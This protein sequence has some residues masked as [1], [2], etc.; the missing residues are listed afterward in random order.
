MKVSVSRTRPNPRVPP[1]KRIARG[2]ITDV[3]QML[4]PVFLV[5]C[6]I[7][8]WLILVEVPGGLAD[9]LKISNAIGISIWSVLVWRMR[10]GRVPDLWLMVVAVPVGVFVGCEV[11]AWMGA[12]NLVTYLIEDPQHQWRSMVGNVVIASFATSFVF[13]FHRAQALRADLEGERRKAAERLQSETSARLALLQA[14]IEPHFLFNTLA[15]VQSVVS[16]DPKLAKEML[17]HLN[18]YLRA[19]LGRSRRM[20][21]ILG[22]ELELVEALLSIATARLGGRLRYTIDVPRNLHC[23]ELA[24]LLLQPLVENALRHGIEPSLDGGEIRIEGEA[25]NGSLR[26]RVC[27][28]GVGLNANS[29]EGVGLSNI[30]ARLSSLYGAEGR[31]TLYANQPRGVIAELL[32]PRSKNGEANADRV[33]RR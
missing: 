20:A 26:M 23:V 18:F 6:L 24:P 30:R 14:Q 12:P 4:L 15:N 2:W 16:H 10:G 25:D 9:S 32:V 13:Y 33:D 22:E 29:P 27:D 21:S 17:E 8:L 19:S 3:V 28:S 5:N 7:A 1:V 31:L 11:A